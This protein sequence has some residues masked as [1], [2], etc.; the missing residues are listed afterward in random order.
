ML[1]RTENSILHEK[2]SR[3]M[4][5]KAELEEEN[6]KLLLHIEAK[7]KAYTALLKDYEEIKPYK[8]KME[9]LEKEL[10]AVYKAY[11]TAL[12]VDYVSEEDL[13]DLDD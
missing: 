9:K 11:H 2:I 8:D 1:N 4:L 13:Y 5:E 12:W 10:S 7:D 6:R 3:L